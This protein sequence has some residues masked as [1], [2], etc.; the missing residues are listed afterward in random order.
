[1]HELVTFRCEDATQ[2]DLS[3]ATVIYMYM[4]PIGI[5]ALRPLLCRLRSGTRVASY[6]FRCCP[7]SNFP[8]LME[9]CWSSN[10]NAEGNSRNNSAFAALVLFI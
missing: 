10:R 7:L 8:C 1:M 3:E 2:A 4:L 9:V 5:E 6:I